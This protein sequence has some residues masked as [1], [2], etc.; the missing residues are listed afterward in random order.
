MILS[1]EAVIDF[2]LDIDFRDPDPQDLELREWI[3]QQWN[4]TRPRR[5]RAKPKP[6]PKPKA[7]VKAKAKANSTVFHPDCPDPHK[8]YV[9]LVNS[10][11]AS[12]GVKRGRPRH[13]CSAK[14]CKCLSRAH[15]VRRLSTLYS[16]LVVSQAFTLPQ[17][18]EWSSIAASFDEQCFAA[19]GFSHGLLFEIAKASLGEIAGGKFVT[20]PERP[21]D[22]RPQDSKRRKLQIDAVPLHGL[23]GHEQGE[24]KE[25]QATK[26]DEVLEELSFHRIASKRITFCKNTLFVP[27][28][29]THILHLDYCTAGLEAVAAWLKTPRAES[30]PPKLLD[31]LW[32]ERSPCTIVLQFSSML[33]EGDPSH[34]ANRLLFQSIGVS[35]CEELVRDHP[36][37]ATT[38]RC[39]Y[40]GA[41]SWLQVK[42][43]DRLNRKPWCDVRPL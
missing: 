37:L 43:V 9:L 19:L 23:D 42:M 21:P 33:L 11:V 5:R 16:I 22:P 8:E 15:T 6:K 2:L 1:V 14:R 18:L 7:N 26:F 41:N 13:H 32:L 31:L 28:S 4:P 39:S 20:P 17:E 3:W 36:D 25:R 24:A 12:A 27:G 34:P 40:V 35:S 38:I 30:Q 10:A 29:V